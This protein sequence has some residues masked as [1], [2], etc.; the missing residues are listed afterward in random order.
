MTETNPQIPP[1]RRWNRTVDTDSIAVNETS[2]M[3]FRDITKLTHAKLG[4]RFL[5]KLLHL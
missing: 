1:A 3:E 4:F 2:E 5:R